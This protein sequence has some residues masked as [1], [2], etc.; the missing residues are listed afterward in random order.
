M[1]TTIQIL[2]VIKEL[3]IEKYYNSQKGYHIRQIFFSYEIK[4][5]KNKK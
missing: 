5:N 3:I 2:K 1:I 4:N